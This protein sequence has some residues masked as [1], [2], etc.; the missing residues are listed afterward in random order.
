MRSFRYVIAIALLFSLQ[1]WAADEDED[2]GPSEPRVLSVFPMGGRQDSVVQTE[3]RGNDLGGAYAVWFECSDLEGQIEEVEEV[4][5]ELATSLVEHHPLAQQAEPAGYVARI[6]I[7]IGGDSKVGLHVLRLITPHGMSNALT[8]QVVGEPVSAEIDSVKYQEVDT[9]VVI[10]GKT[11]ANGDLDFYAFQASKSQQIHFQLFSSFPVY[12]GYS[13][14]SELNL[15]ARSG[16]WFDPERLLR[17]PWHSPALSWV[18]I[19]RLRRQGHGAHHALFPM[20]THRFQQ[21]GTYLVSVGSFL[22]EGN[23]DFVYQLRISTEAPDSSTLLGRDAHPNPAD[24]RE[25]DSSSFA[26]WGSF[27]RPLEVTRL[28]ELAGRSVPPEALKE[29]VADG[30]SGAKDKVEP[31]SA[32]D[33][34]RPLTRFSEREPNDSTGTEVSIYTILEGT[35]DPPG[36]VDT[37]RFQVRTGQSLAFEVETPQSAP[38]QFNPWLQVA[39]PDG[40]DVFDNIHMEYGG[41]GDDVNKTTERKT[42]FT[43]QER[44]SYQLRVRD[45]TSRR[46]GPT[47]SYRVL[48]RPKIPHLGRL[49][50]TLGVTGRRLAPITDH[51]NLAPGKARTFT[52]VCDLEEGFEGDVA[53]SAANLPRGVSVFSA[54]PASYTAGL[55]KGLYYVPVGLESGY[56]GD[57]TRYRP[58]RRAV[59]LAFVAADDALPTKLPLLVDLTARPVFEGRTGPSLPVGKVPLAILASRGGGDGSLPKREYKR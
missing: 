4:R 58:V 57:Q 14:E 19:H 31:E 11:E 20:P 43:F 32:L 1:V 8:F 51:V 22:G 41:D 36:D 15:Y 54:T 34:S 6:Q 52:V 30:N 38:P 5:E 46:G 2:R 33:L 53:V 9:P 26:Q 48:I 10:N 21:D 7:R 17:L 59:S 25:R 3:V 49:E 55:L 50:V 47:L 13:A 27:S 39:G 23:P 35:I 40:Q 29:A 16:S 44:G 37:F 42:V 24:W 56:I 12:I 28:K 45:L 18:P